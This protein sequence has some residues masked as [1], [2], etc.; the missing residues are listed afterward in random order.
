MTHRSFYSRLPFNGARDSAAK[1]QTG[2]KIIWQ[3]DIEG[4]QIFF[5]LTMSMPRQR[6]KT[7]KVM[8]SKKN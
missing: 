1:P 5:S 8:S 4:C 7:Q 3:Y 6:T 2:L